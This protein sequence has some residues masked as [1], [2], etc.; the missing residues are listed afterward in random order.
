M[1]NES[2]YEQDTKERKGNEVPSLTHFRTTSI[3]H[4]LGETVDKDGLNFNSEANV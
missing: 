1:S 2:K 3:H 4:L